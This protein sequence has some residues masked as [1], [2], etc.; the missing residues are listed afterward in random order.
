MGHDYMYNSLGDG[1][2]EKICMNDPSHYHVEQCT[3]TATCYE[4]AC[5]E[6]CN[7]YFG[8][9]IEHSF[10]SQKTTP[11]YLKSEA[12]CQASAQYYYS[13]QYCGATG[14]DSF[15][16]GESCG[17]KFGYYSS[18]GDATC[19]Q[20]GTETATCRFAGCT[21]TDTRTKTNSKLGHNY[22]NWVSDG[23][24]HHIKTCQHNDSHKVTEN[25][26]GGTATCTSRAICIACNS[27]YGAKLA[28]SY[29]ASGKC[30][31]CEIPTFST[32]LAFTLSTNGKYYILS[33]IGSCEDKDIIIPDEYNDLPVT[34]IGQNALKSAAIESVYIP[35]SVTK[36]EASAFENCASLATVTLGEK[37]AS[38]GESAFKNSGITTLTMPNTVTSLGKGAFANCASL[39]TVTFGAGLSTISE[40]AFSGCTTLSTVTFGSGV[41]TIGVQAFS[42]CTTLNNVTIGSGVETISKEAFLDCTALA[43]VTFGEKVASIGEF[44]FKNTGITT[45]T[46]P[47]TVTSLGKGAFANCASLTTVTFGTGLSTI[48]EQAFSGCIALS[49]VTFD[50]KVETI[51][52]Q[53]FS[54]CTTLNNVT[55]GSG[56]ETVSKEAFFDCTALATVTFGE[57]VA[58]IGESAFKNTGITT[59]TMP[60][61]VTSLG[62]GAFA[63]CASLETVTFGTGLSTISE[64]AFLGCT[65]LSTV[66]FGSGVETIGGKAFYGCTTLKNVT[67]GSSVQT[68]SQ[69][70]FAGCT[71][72]TSA[73]IPASVTRIDERAF[74]DCS[75]LTTVNIGL[76]EGA[77]VSSSA[78]QNC[79]T[80]VNVNYTGDINDWVEFLS[81]DI[82]MK[83]DLD[84][85]GSEGRTLTLNNKPVTDVNLTTA[86]YVA[87]RA[88]YRCT[89]LKTVTLGNSV[90][91]IEAYAFEKCTALTTVTMGTGVTSIYRWAF[92]DCSSLNELTIGSNVETICENAFGQCKSLTS[93]TIP[94]SVT[95]IEAWAFAM[96]DAL[97]TLTIGSSVETIGDYAFVGCRSLESVAIPDSVTSIGVNAFEQCGIKTLT[98]GTGILTIGQKVFYECKNLTNVVIP[99]NVTS[100]GIS[101]FRGCSGLTSVTIGSGVTS[102]GDNA[103]TDCVKLVEVINLSSLTITKGANTHGCVGKYA[104]IVKT[105]ATSSIQNENDYVFITDSDNTNYLIDYV[106]SNTLLNLPQKYNNQNYVISNYAFQNCKNVTHL[107]M[108]DGVT[109]VGSDLFGDKNNLVS[110]TVGKNVTEIKSGAFSY[111]YKLV[112]VINL[113]NLEINVGDN[114]NGSIAYRA[115]T[116]KTDGTTSI[117]T[118]NGYLFYDVSGTNISYLVGYSGTNTA[119][120]LPSDYRS[121][122]N[123]AIYAYA[124]YGRDITSVAISGNVTEIQSKA[125]KNCSNLTTVTFSDA[126]VRIPYGD[127]FEGCAKL[128]YNEHNNACYLGDGDQNKYWYLIKAKSKNITSCS[129]PLGCRLIAGSAF[130]S[131]TELTSVALNDGLQIIE[132]GAFWGCN[133]LATISIPDSVRHIE[134]DV[135]YGCNSL[136]YTTYENGKY[137]GNSDNSYLWLMDMVNSQ[138][139][140]KIHKDCV[141]IAAEAFEWAQ[142]TDLVMPSG[143]K[144]IG[145]NAFNGCDNLQ[146]LYYYGDQ[147]AWSAD[148]FE[149]ISI[150]LGDKDKVYFYSETQPTATETAKNFWYYDTDN[151]PAIW[152]NK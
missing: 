3:G 129:L 131:C 145:R 10:V 80:F 85:G 66:T 74:S 22:G 23:N 92:M 115:L 42:E 148:D 99:N 111:C 93:V 52:V 9:S 26:A 106:G 18:N 68:I 113:S 36:I 98:I 83:I 32:G 123:Y 29:T 34:H 119:L 114:G 7:N 97:K 73:T 95:T 61:S 104:L 128:Q 62:K 63:N 140:I 101:A 50:S 127:V 39:T 2:H 86:R 135:F 70:A 43:T 14:E 59:L 21:E 71:A 28:H 19:E 112:E 58:S 90:E 46:M 134:A 121:G 89:T 117:S 82:F 142:F 33:G 150:G 87:S 54:G 31:V 152:T 122:V 27:E 151:K 30:S 133:N 17:H 147:L 45:L 81:C 146:H 149:K 48:P 78:F 84:E 65:T 125:F 138:N 64:Q 56:V 53:A 47:N 105:T 40:Q 5:C 49:S 96:C 57:N 20:D 91:H 100:I 118:H 41:E 136:S 8:Y 94:D 110:V 15:P 88:F 137:L 67:I 11:Q 4:R 139:D 55:I 25:C 132:N 12:T 72:L 107:V 79:N 102:I 143:I 141:K 144:Y 77:G 124:F 16:Y 24:G 130:F 108:S 120:T 109:S 35:Y 103:F 1:V 60:N 37:V 76:K 51:G 126:N 69:E 6:F 38:I 44:A 75:A 116:V 13:C